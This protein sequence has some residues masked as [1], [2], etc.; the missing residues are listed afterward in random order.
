MVTFQPLEIYLR[1]MFVKFRF[2]C[3]GMA[4]INATG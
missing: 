2:T 4:D 3:G 1:P